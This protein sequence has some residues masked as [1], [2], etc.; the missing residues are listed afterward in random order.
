MGLLWSGCF[1]SVVC[2]ASGNESF[3]AGVQNS[4]LKIHPLLQARVLS[5]K[6]D[7]PLYHLIANS[8]R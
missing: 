2:T 1:D 3:W 5:Q 7:L 6:L 4:A 8:N